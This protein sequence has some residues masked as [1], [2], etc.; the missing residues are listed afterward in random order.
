MQSRKCRA[1]TELLLPDAPA[2]WAASSQAQQQQELQ[3]LPQAQPQ[4]ELGL[5]RP[6]ALQ[7][8][9]HQGWGTAQKQHLPRRNACREA[10]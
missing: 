8:S 4:Q 6:L 5:L 2:S 9:A 7:R 3:E 10:P 1:S